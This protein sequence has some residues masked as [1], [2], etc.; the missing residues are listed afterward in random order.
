MSSLLTPEPPRNQRG[1]QLL[2]PGR[3][4][5]TREEIAE[6]IKLTS[7]KW[8]EETYSAD[9]NAI[10]IMY[11]DNPFYLQQVRYNPESEEISPCEILS[12]CPCLFV[13][14]DKSTGLNKL[15]SNRI[16]R[17][18][19]AGVERKFVAFEGIYIFI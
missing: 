14:P 17:D 8:G 3:Y 13:K 12:G 18:H 6:F 4:D 1:R 15:R 5:Y 2:N 9:A 7:N 10:F 11:Y 19:I 16:Y